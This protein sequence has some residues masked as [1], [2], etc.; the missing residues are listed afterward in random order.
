MEKF[1]DS[2][3]C[4]N[5]ILKDYPDNGDVLFDKSRVLAKLE[6]FDDSINTLKHAISVNRKFQLK[7]KSDESFTQLRKNEKFLEIVTKSI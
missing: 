5:S 3:L 4:C 6:Y 7:A 1:E 2:I